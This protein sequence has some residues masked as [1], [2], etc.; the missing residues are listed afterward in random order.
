MIH[1]QDTQL[2]MRLC[3][4]CTLKVYG[5]DCRIL[6]DSRC[7]LKSV[8]FC[9]LACGCTCWVL[10]YQ[11]L[12]LQLHWM[13]LGLSWWLPLIKYWVQVV[14]SSERH[15]ICS[16]EFRFK[17]KAQLGSIRLAYLAS[18]IALQHE[19]KIT[20]CFGLLL[21]FSPSWLS[22]RISSIVSPISWNEAGMLPSGEGLDKTP[23]T[24]SEISQEREIIFSWISF[25]AEMLSPCPISSYSNSWKRYLRI[26][27]Q[28]SR[29]ERRTDLSK[30]ISDS[31]PQSQ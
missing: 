1:M 10:K 17:F 31:L 16:F 24:T 18:L 20:W 30:S 7:W 25:H 29:Q 14:N 27:H 8:C 3:V 9:W 26:S 28:H 5:V 23:K 19:L 4:E 2:R 21:S 11:V 15:V 22:S 13:S 12:P 6:T